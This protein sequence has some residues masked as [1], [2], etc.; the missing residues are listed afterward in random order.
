MIRIS[1]FL[2]THNPALFVNINK[3][4]P[5][6]PGKLPI[7]ALLGRSPTHVVV[8][9]IVP[10]LHIVFAGIGVILVQLENQVA[11]EGRA[12]GAV[13]RVGFVLPL[14]GDALGAG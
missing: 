6:S 8:V 4:R 13:A 12:L 11:G 9:P 7:L 2:L 5:D 14:L 1:L 3:L 10:Q